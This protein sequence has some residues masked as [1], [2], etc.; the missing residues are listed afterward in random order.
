MA[1]PTSSLAI[2]IDLGTTYSCVGVWKDGNVE[3]IPNTNGNRITPSW[4]SYTQEERIVGDGAKNQSAMN[5]KNSVYDAKRLIGRDFNDPAVAQDIKNWPFKVANV[6]GLPRIEVEYRGETKQYSP[7]E[8]SACV[9]TYLKETAESYLGEAVTDAVITVPAYFDNSQRQATKDAGQIAGLN[10]LRI[11]NEPT[12]AALC[13]GIGTDKGVDKKVLI[14]DLGGG[15]FDVTVLDIAD[16]IFD[17]KATG[18][19][20]HLGGQDFDNLICNHM[21]KEFKKKTGVE[22]AGNARAMRRLQAACEKAKRALSSG[23]SAV[24]DVES[25]AE[26]HDFSANIT[27]AKFEELCNTLFQKCLT[28]V[29]NVLKDAKVTNKDIDE[30]VLVGGSTR[31]PKIQTMLSDLFEKKELCKSV[32]PD[33]AVAFGAAIQA[34]ILTGKKDKALQSMVLVDVTP[35]SLGVETQ[36][37]VMAVVIPRNTTI[38]CKKT[39]PFTTTEANQTVITIPVYEGERPQCSGNN[40]LGT[41]EL[42]GIPP[43]PRG[44]AKIE[45]SFDLDANGILQVTAQDKATGRENKIVIAN[46]KGRLSEAQI[47]A[48]IADAEKNREADALVRKKI[49]AKNELEAYA[50]QLKEAI[51][52]M[53]KM[54]VSDRNALANGVKHTLQWLDANMESCD[55]Q[56]I[57]QKRN[58]FESLYTPIVTKMYSK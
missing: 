46:N 26:G 20:T 17:V 10:V 14:F 33:E 12:A 9:L 34:A 44:S 21:I 37:G 55:L 16:G 30:I 47:A 58:V 3:I 22:V 53:Q 15:T 18:G 52:S 29:K 27:R 43:A 28:T 56:S 13:Y 38:P 23:T 41:F 51:D 49:E 6:D 1:A 5:P 36:G 45:I 50:F 54:N 48:M 2:G 4:V 40:L 24:I 11:I 25:L 42:T 32:N 7:Q 35:L 57:Q 39:E 31:I 8:V 19:D